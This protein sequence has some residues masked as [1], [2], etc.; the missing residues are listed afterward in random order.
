MWKP[1]AHINFNFLDEPRWKGLLVRQEDP[2]LPH[3]DRTVQKR[4]KWILNWQSSWKKQQLSYQEENF[5]PRLGKMVPFCKPLI[6]IPKTGWMEKKILI[7][8][9]TRKFTWDFWTYMRTKKMTPMV[10]AAYHPLSNHHSAS[11]SPSFLLLTSPFC[12]SMLM[13]QVFKFNF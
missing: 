4:K 7:I 1:W 11:T 5:R 13:A 2:H 3:F 10:W 12:T 9:T 6:L 8:I